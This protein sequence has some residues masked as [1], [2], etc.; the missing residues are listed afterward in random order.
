MDER[1]DTSLAQPRPRRS[2]TST[3]RRR[4]VRSEFAYELLSSTATA[5]LRL[6]WA[7]SRLTSEPTPSQAVF[8][9]NA[10]MII[11]TWHS[12]A[13]LLP[14]LRARHYPVDVLVSR[15][16]DGE[17]I[18]RSLRK[19]GCGTVRGAGATDRTRMFE[20]GSVAAFR[21]LKASLDNQHSVVMTA[22]YDRK[23]RGTVSPGVIALARLT[24]RPII[25]AVV[26]T[27]NRFNVR[28]W[29][30]TAINLPF[31]R[32]VFVHAGPIMVPR[33]AGEGELEEK[34]LEVERALTDVTAR[35]YAIADRRHG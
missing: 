4:L 23:S 28:S 19:L 32:A 20:K 35:A 29:D 10:P 3:L 27:R 18:S 31:G 5:Y 11:T 2:W 25:P 8:H 17:I 12:E 16:G 7:T 22:D 15:A 30:R 9:N 33:R 1:P 13:F 26:V 6:V 21:G 24:Q 34:R 14:L